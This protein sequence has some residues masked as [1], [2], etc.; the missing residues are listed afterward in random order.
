MS[1]KL[2]GS[3][4][5]TYTQSRSIAVR[6]IACI[7]CQSGTYPLEAKYLQK[8]LN[9]TIY[10]KL[11][12]LHIS[13]RDGL[14]GCQHILLKWTKYISVAPSFSYFIPFFTE[15]PLGAYPGIQSAGTRNK[16]GCDRREYSPQ[17]LAASHNRA[18]V[19]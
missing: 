8:T 10:L 17:P 14:H 12:T 16:N 18:H 11:Y 6:A 2:S 5:L 19:L 4:C 1:L 3:Y 7:R 13:Y 15:Y 9:L